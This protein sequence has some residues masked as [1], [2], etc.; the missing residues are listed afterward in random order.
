LTYGHEKDTHFPSLK[1][2]GVAAAICLNCGF[3]AFYARDVLKMREALQQ[4]P[5]WFD[6]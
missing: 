2:T 3:T 4:H 5:E 6:L 1:E